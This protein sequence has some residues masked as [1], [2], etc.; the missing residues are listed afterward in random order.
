MLA[1]LMPD[2][3]NKSFTS[4]TLPDGH[5]RAGL[6]DPAGRFCWAMPTAG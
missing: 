6:A 2:E 1:L 3:V 5:E 4:L